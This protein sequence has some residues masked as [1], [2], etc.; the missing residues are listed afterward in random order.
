MSERCYKLCD[1]TFRQLCP[2][3]AKSVPKWIKIAGFPAREAIK[4]NV[5]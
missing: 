4:V 1:R 2:S 3:E 5:I